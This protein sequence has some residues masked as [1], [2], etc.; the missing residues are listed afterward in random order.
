[1][2]AMAPPCP[3]ARDDMQCLWLRNAIAEQA[4]RAGLQAQTVALLARAVAP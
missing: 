4:R 3:H 2:R 1:M